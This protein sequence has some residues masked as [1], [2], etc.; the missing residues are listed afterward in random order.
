V[1]SNGQT[2]R[3]PTR[4]RIYAYLAAA[5]LKAPGAGGWLRVW[6]LAHALDPQGSGRVERERLVQTLQRLGVNE[7]S[8]RR[9]ISQGLAAGVFIAW[10]DFLRYRSPVTVAQLLDVDRVG[11]VVTIPI[12]KLFKRGWRSV[13]YDAALAGLPAVKRETPV[14]RLALQNYTGLARGTQ[15]RHEKLAGVTTSPNLAE[16]KIRPELIAGLQE[17][18]WADCTLFVKL[19]DKNGAR[20]PIVFKRLPDTRKPGLARCGKFGRSKKINDVLYGL[21]KKAV[22]AFERVRLYH[23]KAKGASNS[24]KRLVRQDKPRAT[25]YSPKRNPE[26]GRLWQVHYTDIVDFLYVG[27]DKSD[28]Y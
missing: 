21:S 10:H 27:A 15:R 25:F 22:R 8:A 24:Y 20:V 14:S 1:K 28:T 3:I 6:I 2:K 19:T 23:R 11:R 4:G 7:R 16:T 5:A 18:G 13:I 9:W 26:G 17:F 12:Y